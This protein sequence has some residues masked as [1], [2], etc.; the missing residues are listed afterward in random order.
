MDLVVKDI[1]K[2]EFQEDWGGQHYLM[3]QRSQIECG[4]RLELWI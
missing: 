1:W 3:L 2:G 4:L